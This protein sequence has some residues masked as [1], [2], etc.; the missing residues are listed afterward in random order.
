MT[1]II[2]LVEVLFV[3]CVI[4]IVCALNSDDMDE[5]LGSF[6]VLMLLILCLAKTTITTQYHKY[7]K[8]EIL[9]EE[10]PNDKANEDAQVPM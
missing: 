3:L 1:P 6:L 9:I 5:G 8:L 4:F 7:Q 10:V 2:I